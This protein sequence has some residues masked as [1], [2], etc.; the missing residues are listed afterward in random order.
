MF[1]LLYI[2]IGLVLTFSFTNGMKDG[3]NVMATAISSQSISRKHSLIIVTISEFIGP[4]LFGIPVAITVAK[5]I[6]NIDILPHN[7]D[8][9][10]LIL[11]G[12]AGAI[13]WNFLTWLFSLPTSSSFALVGGLIGP[14]IFRYG[15]NAVPWAVFLVKVIGAMFLSPVLGILFGYLIYRLFKYLLRNSTLKANKYLKE[16]QILT[17]IALALSHGTNDSQKA[18]GIIA[19]LL[20][21][22]GILPSISIPLWV[23]AVSAFVLAAGITMGGTKIIKTVGYSIFRVRPIHSFTSQISAFS[24]LLACN[25]LGAPVS[26]TQIISSSVIGV[27]SAYRPKSVKWKV[28]YNIFLS[29][30]LTIPLAGAVAALVYILLR[31]IIFGG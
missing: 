23:M 21:L 26:T 14:V 30:F 8:S 2:S 7:M 3:C 6:I 20:V 4:F 19:L 25:L 12:V 29:W 10:L 5:G 18:M 27:G 16:V 24:I 13:L 22:A 1:F 28:I 31:K 15:K 9:I 17:L 11:S